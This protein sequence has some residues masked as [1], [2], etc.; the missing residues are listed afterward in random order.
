MAHEETFMRGN[1]FLSTDRFF[2]SWL[3]FLFLARRWFS[4]R[5]LM[6]GSTNDGVWKVFFL[7]LLFM[8]QGIACCLNLYQLTYPNTSL[9]HSPGLV[10]SWPVCNK[11]RAVSLSITTDSSLAIDRSIFFNRSGLGIATLWRFDSCSMVRSMFFSFKS[12]YHNLWRSSLLFVLSC[13]ASQGAPDFTVFSPQ[14]SGKSKNSSSPLLQR[15]VCKGLHCWPCQA[16]EM[17]EDF[18]LFI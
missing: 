9:L 16:G 5:S 18:C 7:Y 17:N 10:F 14:F 6:C 4:I 12:I 3:I 2:L 1:L 15:V 13:L 8:Y 11:R